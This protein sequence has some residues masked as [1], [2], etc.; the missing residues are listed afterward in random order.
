[1]TSLG[2]CGMTGRRSV[3]RRL[4]FWT[5]ILGCLPQRPLAAQA[6][7]SCL[8]LGKTVTIRGGLRRI[9]ENGYWRWIA[10]LPDRPICALPD[11]ADAYPVAADHATPIQTFDRDDENVR[12]RLERLVGRNAEVTGT[13]TQWHT[14]YRRAEVVLL[15]EKVE[16]VDAA[17]RTALASPSRP[18]PDVRDLAAYEITVRAGRSLIKQARKV[19]S[20]KPLV[21]VD[22]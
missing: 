1:M 21:P 2:N 3:L 9:D 16:P 19:G 7:S 20:N 11:P 4:A 5:L 10:L 8:P 6:V 17:G 13:P 22:E 14:G 18:R 15:V 12:S